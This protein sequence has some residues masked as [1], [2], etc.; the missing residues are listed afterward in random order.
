[1]LKR[2]GFLG[3]MLGA[4]VVAPTVGTQNL[5]EFP[6]ASSSNYGNV[7]I[8]AKYSPQN[9][10]NDITAR[11]AKFKAMR[12]LNLPWW[13]AGQENQFSY[14]RLE[15]PLQLHYESFKSVSPCMKSSMFRTALESRNLDRQENSLAQELQR[16]M[17]DQLG[18]GGNE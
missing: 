16:L 3:G 13:K 10:I 14:E 17:F 18:L 8:P 9:Q 11:L 6:E 5:G 12:K 7:G 1:M 2:R 4:V 15:R